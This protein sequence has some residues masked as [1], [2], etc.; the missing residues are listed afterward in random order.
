MPVKM[1]ST[2]L[3]YLEIRNKQTLKTLENRQIN[4]LKSHTVIIN[5]QQKGEERKIKELIY[6]LIAGKELKF[7]NLENSVITIFIIILLFSIC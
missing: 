3:E 2:I 7:N 1:S 5:R 6:C 4:K